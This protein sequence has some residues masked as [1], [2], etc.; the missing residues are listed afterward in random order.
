MQYVQ[1]LPRLCLSRSFLRLPQTV[2]HVLS[3]ISKLH[4]QNKAVIFGGILLH[5]LFHF[6]LDISLQNQILL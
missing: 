2:P 5:P 4:Q 3:G 1:H 6:S